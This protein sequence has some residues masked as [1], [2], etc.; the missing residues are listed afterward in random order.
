M[1]LNAFRAAIDGSRL[2]GS[3]TYNKKSG[4]VSTTGVGDDVGEI[5]FAGVD[6]NDPAAVEEAMRKAPGR[7]GGSYMYLVFADNEHTE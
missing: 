7:V 1:R 4:K 6:M 2:I 3:V 5:A